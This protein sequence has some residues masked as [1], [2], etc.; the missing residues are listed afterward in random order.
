[1]ILLMSETAKPLGVGLVSCIPHQAQYPQ[2]RM[3]KFGIV[4]VEAWVLA[5]IKAK[6]NHRF[7]IYALK[8]QAIMKSR[9]KE[10]HS[11]WHQGRGTK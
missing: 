4:R 8:K 3:I 11:L 7:S 10:I 1:M 9:E 5:T 2:S 6:L